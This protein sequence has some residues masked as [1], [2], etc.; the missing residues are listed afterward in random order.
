MGGVNYEL[1]QQFLVEYLSALELTLLRF[2]A[3]A[4]LELLR[5]V[6]GSIKDSDDL[7]IIADLTVIDNQTHETLQ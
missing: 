3:F 4:M 2:S 6:L 5:T 7:V 1:I